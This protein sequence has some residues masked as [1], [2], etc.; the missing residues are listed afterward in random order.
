MIRVAAAQAASAWLDPA[1]TTS[2]VV[3]MLEHASRQG[4]EL[5][6][7]NGWCGAVATETDYAPIASGRCV[8]AA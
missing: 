5:V 2:K 6:A 8:L 3:A 1:A 4:V 7:P